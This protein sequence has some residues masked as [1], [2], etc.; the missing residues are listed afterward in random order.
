[1]E[2][3]IAAGGVV[4]RKAEDGIK[5]LLIKDSYGHW[6]WPK[7]HAEEGETVS[8]TAIREVQEETGIKELVIL[9]KVGQQEYIYPF[10]GIDILKI[11]YIF[12]METSQENLV[13]QTS[14]IDE[15]KWF[16]MEEAI[17]VIGYEGS[18]V[19][20]KNALDTYKNK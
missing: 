20:L 18:N 1:M 15:G 7:G 9:Q 19:I 17:D 5:V 8:E 4:V 14:E 6:I 3:R 16:S 13:I 11:V 10:E 2:K 12:L